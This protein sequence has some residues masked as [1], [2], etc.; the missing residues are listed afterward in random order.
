MKADDVDILTG[1]PMLRVE[2]G[3]R[4]RMSDGDHLL[5]RP[6]RKPYAIEA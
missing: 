2:R 6:Q 4:L 3:N 5:S 1:D